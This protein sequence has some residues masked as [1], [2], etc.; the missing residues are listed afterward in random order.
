MTDKELGEEVMSWPAG[1][2]PNDLKKEIT[3]RIQIQR[4]KKRIEEIQEEER[5]EKKRRNHPIQDSIVYTIPTPPR[6]AG[7]TLRDPIDAA[8]KKE[9]QR[10]KEWRDGMGGKK[11]IVKWL[12]CIQGSKNPSRIAMAKLADSVIHSEKEWAI[13][14]TAGLCGYEA[15]K[16]TEISK[17]KAERVPKIQ[18]GKR[19][20][21]LVERMIQ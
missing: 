2:Q 15:K 9:A 6:V 16:R 19:K 4:R 13:R 10:K 17:Y 8:E 11:S 3:K 7:D 12:W 5:E 20:L 1:Q 18:C 21:Y 14:T